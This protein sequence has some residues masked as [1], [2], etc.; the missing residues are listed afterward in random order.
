MGRN[1]KFHIALI[2]L[3]PVNVKCLVFG[4]MVT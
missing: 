1:I 3:K 2:V 4:G